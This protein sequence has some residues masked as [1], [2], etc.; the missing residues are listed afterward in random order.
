MTATRMFHYLTFAV[1]GLFCLL[2]SPPSYASERALSFSNYSGVDFSIALSRGDTIAVIV[3]DRDDCSI[4][5]EQE[6][7][8]EDALSILGIFQ[9]R[10]FVADFERDIKFSQTYKVTQPAT[11]VLF[12]NGAEVG[13]VTGT[14]DFDSLCSQLLGHLL[15]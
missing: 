7:A 6:D 15:I 13:R 9:L 2:H 5:E 14:S 1:L 12:A 3:S 10:T 8:L 11:I 4:C